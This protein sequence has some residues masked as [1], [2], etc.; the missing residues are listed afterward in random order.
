LQGILT[1]GFSWYHPGYDIAGPVGTP[2]AASKGGIIAEASCGWN[3]GYGC[4]VI[5]NHGNGWSTMYAHMVS[6]PIVSVGESVNA[7]QIIGYRGNTGRSTGPHTHFEIRRNNIAVNP[8]A[9]LQ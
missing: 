2:I 8:G 9:Y 4:H 7:G 1:Q 3:W 6:L 5:I